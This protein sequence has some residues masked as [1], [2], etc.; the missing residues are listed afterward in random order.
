MERDRDATQASILARCACHTLH[1]T[2]EGKSGN[3]SPT[4]VVMMK[5]SMRLPPCGWILD[6]FSRQLKDGANTP[7]WWPKLADVSDQIQ[8]VGIELA[9]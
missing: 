2:T 5:Y 8:I 1:R 9:P 6:G 3:E 7:D 4:A